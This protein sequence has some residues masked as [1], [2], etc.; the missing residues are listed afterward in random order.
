M[1]NPKVVVRLYP[2]DED[3]DSFAREIVNSEANKSL[4]IPSIDQIHDVA[5]SVASTASNASMD[6]NGD[7]E[8]LLYESSLQLH[9]DSQQSHDNGFIIGR[10]PDCDV[11]VP[12]LKGLESIAEYHCAILFDGRSRLILRD[13]QE[14]HLGDGPGGTAVAYN[15]QGG[16]TR[17]SFTW[18]LFGDDFVDN[19]VPIV[20]TLSDTLKFR[21]VVSLDN[22]S[23]APA[24]PTRPKGATGGRERLG[25]TDN[26][27]EP[28]DDENPKQRAILVKTRELGRGAQA[29]VSQVWNVS[30]GLEYASKDP[31]DRQYWQRL[32]KESELLKSIHHV[33]VHA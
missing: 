16:Y 28:N 1:D 18:I 5:T 20:V 10:S 8:S 2:A 14:P 33:R 32:T 12:D 21:V 25:L 17:R 7:G 30:T 31:L 11:V 15:G 3:L 24:L 27:V 26:V 22:Q 4:W 13:L 9:I 6:G 29:T 23:D 19:G